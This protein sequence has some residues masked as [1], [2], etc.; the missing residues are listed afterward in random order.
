MFIFQM[1]LNEEHLILDINAGW[2]G[3]K[4]QFLVAGDL[5][6]PISD[7]LIRP[8]PNREALVDRRKA[9]FNSRL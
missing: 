7:I 2:Q 4:H 5:G 1:V 6:Y 3:A 8:Y 9:E